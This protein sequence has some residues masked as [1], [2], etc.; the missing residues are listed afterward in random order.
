MRSLSTEII[1]NH[2]VLPPLTS[3]CIAALSPPSL[4][5]PPSLLFMEFRRCSNFESHSRYTYGQHLQPHFIISLLFLL[6]TVGENHDHF[7]H[8]TMRAMFNSK[9]GVFC[10]Q[11][12]TSKKKSPRPLAYEPTSL[13]TA[14]P[15][16][17][18]MLTPAL[19]P[20]STR[21]PVSEPSGV[22]SLCP[23]RLAEIWG[24]Y[25]CR[26]IAFLNPY[27]NILKTGFEVEITR[28]ERKVRRNLLL[29]IYALQT[30]DIVMSTTYIFDSTVFS[31]IRQCSKRANVSMKCTRNIAGGVRPPS[32]QD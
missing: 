6:L 15:E 17:T 20:L 18:P 14:S 4:V 13:P 2:R 22:L 9:N 26:G 28:E 11:F 19:T 7:E 27:G 8:R 1:S 23:W 30:L 29:T 24:K 10:R 5:R 16:A 32:L 3:A 25:I 12:T 21:M 31:C